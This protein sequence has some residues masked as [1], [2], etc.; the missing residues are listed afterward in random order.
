MLELE[1]RASVPENLR[2][3]CKEYFSWDLKDFQVE[4]LEAMFEGG[5]L[6]INLPT[7]HSKSTLGCFLFPLLS[8]M[9]NPNETHIIC[10]ANI[11]DS[12]RRVQALELEIETNKA[13]VR[14][15]PWIGKP[16][17]KEGRIWSSVQFNVV[18]RTINKPNP[19]VLAA[20][21]GSADIKGR[22]GK[23]MC[24]DIEGED[25]RW[26]PLKREQLYSWLKLEAWRCYEDKHDSDRPLIC[27][28]GTPFDVDSIYFRVEL[29]GW[30]VIRYPVYK[31]NSHLPRLDRF[32][33][34]MRMQPIYLWPEKA[35]KVERAR[36][37]LR[38][39]QFSI[40]YLMD[41]TGGDSSKLSSTEIQ[42]ATQEAEFPN[43]SFAGFVSLDPASGSSNRQADYAGISVLKINWPQGEELPSV[44]VQEAHNFTDGLF[45]QVHFCADLSK[46]YGYP[47]IFEV[48]GQQGGTYQNSFMHLHP[49]IKL[50]RHYTSASNKF[51]TAMGLTVVKTLVSKKKLHVPE[52]VLDSEGIQALVQEL[53]DLRPPFKTA[54]H[55]CA[56]IWFA[57]R[58]AYERIRH[59]KGPEIQ[60][61]FLKPYKSRFRPNPV[62]SF[63]FNQ[64]S[65][66]DKLILEER[67]KEERKFY[68]QL[69]GIK[70]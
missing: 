61:T 23:L 54:D 11:N 1:R 16:E 58:Y 67:K 37:S 34:Q 4:I 20:A 45:E 17:E 3:I 68:N 60:S 39:L 36:K 13:L 41:P 50:L 26:S 5:Y 56:S 63:G 10:G 30:K 59:Y 66:R 28:L 15:F 53:R 29:E 35:D 51:D 55:I 46:E 38:K 19:S 48:N 69:N 21:V 2:E 12:K 42:T 47:V 62:L 6:A 43:A 52:S 22:R 44:E 32:G 7:D 27:L 70:E 49:E 14:D 9:E 57:V 65:E 24:D 64:M 25:A 8:L 18:G 40:A 33:E 31:D